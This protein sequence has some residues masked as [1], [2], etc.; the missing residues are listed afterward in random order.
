MKR[1]CGNETASPLR[2][3]IMP[4]VIQANRYNDSVVGVVSIVEL[5]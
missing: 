3:Q 2:I 5:R 4:V 1:P